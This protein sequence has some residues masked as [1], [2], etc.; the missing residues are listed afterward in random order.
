MRARAALTGALAGLRPISLDEVL[1]EAALQVRVDRKYLVPV[2][3]FVELVTRLRDRFA[4]LEIDG[5]R[6]FRYESVYFDTP[7]HG[8]YR[9][10]LQRRRYRY[11]VRT[12]T[13]LDSGECSFEVKLKGNRAETIKSRLPYA[14]A[15]RSR[16]TG[17]A[18][19]FLA[20]QLR[21]AYGVPPVDGLRP[22]LVTTYRRS[23]LTDPRAHERMTCDIDLRF[24]DQASAIDV[25]PETVLVETKT[26]SHAGAADQVLRDLRLRPIHVSKYCVAAAMLNP[27]LPANPW[28][29]TVASLR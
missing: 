14:A 12:R 6:S 29:R 7:S 11:K 26:A 19:D 10:H 2:G 13:Y 9:Q 22:A 17:P 20:G 25:L 1:A 27:N 24:F 23:T 16:L 21:T 28:H 4:V 5:Q 18:H 3:T 15:D 8:L